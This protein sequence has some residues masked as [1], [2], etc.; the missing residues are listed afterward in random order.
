MRFDYLEP[1]SLDDALA[2][3]TKYK[4]KA[5]IIAG[6]TDVM[7]QARNKAIKPDYLVD[8]TNIPGLEYIKFDDKKGLKIGSLITVRALE[9]SAE[10]QKEYPIIAQAAGQIGSIA[11]RNVATLGGNLC[12]ALGR[13][14]TGHGSPI[15]RSK[16]NRPQR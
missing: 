5:R 10:L 14:G 8:I 11:I 12:A 9:T 3:L 16:S 2:L 4:D 6:G 13:D 15:S 1:K 7:L